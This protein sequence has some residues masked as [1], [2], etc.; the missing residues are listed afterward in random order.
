MNSIDISI[1]NIDLKII[2]LEYYDQTNTIYKLK[3]AYNRVI[4]TKNLNTTC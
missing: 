4:H 3:K 2:V 1:Y